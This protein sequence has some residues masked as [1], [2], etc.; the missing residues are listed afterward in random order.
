MVT[1]VISNKFGWLWFRLILLLFFQNNSDKY[2]QNMYDLTE[3]FDISHAF[4]EKP[5]FQNSM[6]LLASHIKL[7]FHEG[8]RHGKEQFI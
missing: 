5:F 6:M 8:L 3:S 4:S 1:E 7:R 2:T